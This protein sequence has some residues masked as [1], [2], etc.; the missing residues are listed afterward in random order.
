MTDTLVPPTATVDHPLAMLSAAEMKRA[1]EIILGCGRLGP[2]DRAAAARF[3]HLVLHEP[4][5]A[6]VLAWQPGDPIDR[7]VRA[8]VVPGA[9][10]D[11]VE[12][13]VSVTTGS[14][15]EWQVVEGMRPAL[16]FGE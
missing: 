12:A 8:L 16:M 13:V 1:V 11:I 3:V 7:Q 10:L 9:A 15:I 6:A 5:K 14:F 4:A 2:P